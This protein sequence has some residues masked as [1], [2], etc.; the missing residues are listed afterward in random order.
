MFAECERIAGFPVTSADLTQCLAVV[1]E[2]LEAAARQPASRYFV[3]ANPHSLEIARADRDFAMAISDADLVIPDGVGVVVAS[4]LTGGRIRERVTG[5]MLF[6]GVSEL[7]NARAGSVYFLGSTEPVLD[8]IGER[9]AVDYPDV[10]IAGMTSPPFAPSIPPRANDRL[11][12]DINSAGPDVVWVG[13][14]A[15]KQEKWIHQNRSRVHAKLLGPIGAAFDFYAG[16]VKRPSP[17]F[18]DH[19][20]EWFPRL[21]REPGRLWRRN[22]VSAP[23][24][25]ARA[26]LGARFRDD[27]R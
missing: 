10:R 22:V 12:D 17:W 23:K 27:V 24:F 9:F 25:F 26:V 18:Q 5:T 11:I 4:R 15:P 1:E 8:R 3:C 13:M 21:L 16:T 7:L 2:W 6:L 20:L 14:T 19:G